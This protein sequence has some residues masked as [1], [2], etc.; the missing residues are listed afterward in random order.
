ML[1]S[2]WAEFVKQV[3][4]RGWGVSWTILGQLAYFA[5]VAAGVKLLTSFLGPW[6]FGIMALGLTVAG[7]G[8]L[9]FYGPFAQ[10]VLRF[11][12]IA[13][14]DGHLAEYFSA[15]ARY[16]S[17]STRGILALTVCLSGGV[18]LLAGEERAGILFFSLLFMVASGMIA[19]HMAVHNA[20]G[21]HALVASTQAV[22]AWLR[23]AL[24]MTGIVLFGPSATVALGGYMLASAGVAVFLWVWGRRKLEGF[25]QVLE[26][27]TSASESST[28]QMV[29]YAIPFMAFAVFGAITSYGDRWMIKLCCGLADVGVYAALYQVAYAPLVILSN[30]ISQVLLPL[31]YV[32]AGD[33]S[34]SVN[35][36]GA[37]IAHWKMLV[38]SGFC[39]LGWVVVTYVLGEPLLRLITTPEFARSHDLLWVLAIGGAIFYFGQ[40]L[41]IEGLYKLQPRR[42]MFPKA[43]HASTFFIVAWWLTTKGTGVYGIAIASIVGSVISVG[44]ILYVNLCAQSERVH[45]PKPAVS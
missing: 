16:Q 23:V 38:A 24:A 32:H 30:A 41:S 28:R 19:V 3:I 9:M 14:K 15:I 11:Y 26:K 35:L 27:G 42:Y 6:T 45:V 8:S 21:N 43:M 37:R 20:A 12:T 34:E 10:A 13:R 33:G 40:F 44:A 2:V 17:V 7:I 22:E 31:V 36:Q 25:G 29:A 4:N 5:G 1:K 18:L 39:L